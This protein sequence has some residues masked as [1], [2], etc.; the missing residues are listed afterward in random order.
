MM[1][2]EWAAILRRFGQRVEVY[3]QEGGAGTAL[4]AFI[5]PVLEQKQTPYFLPTRAAPG[6]AVSLSGSPQREA[7]GRSQPGGVAGP[8]L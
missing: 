1:D 4:R 7:G 6:G 8:G 2:R 5:Q 3:E